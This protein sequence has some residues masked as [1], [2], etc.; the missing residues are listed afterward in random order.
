MAWYNHHC[1][2]VTRDDHTSTTSKLLSQITQIANRP[3]R[4]HLV[5]YYQREY[6]E[7]RIQDA[8]EEEWSRVYAAYNTRR[9]AAEA[10]GE[11]FDE[12]PPQAVAI[13]TATAAKCWEQEDQAFKNQV[14]EEWEQ[15]WEIAKEEYARFA[16][17]PSTPQD[18]DSYVIC[19]IAH[20][21][22]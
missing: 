2:K 14:T 4:L 21:V 5:Q 22:Y 12:S 7:E 10:A 16:Q 20:L 1:S 17:S 3:H 19:F 6:Y 11:Q 8:Y 13:R 18:Y 9:D 15:D